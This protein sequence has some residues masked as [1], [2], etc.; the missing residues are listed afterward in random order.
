[1]DVVKTDAGYVSGTVLGE[2]DKQINV[3][4]G[5]PYASPPI[6]DLRWKLPQPVAPW[7][8]IR[9]CTVCGTMAPQPPNLGIRE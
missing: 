5:I 2:P 9:E 4:R 7:S 1:M 6:G 3:Y 8:G